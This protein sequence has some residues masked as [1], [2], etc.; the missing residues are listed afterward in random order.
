MSKNNL[1]IDELAEELEAFAPREKDRSYSKAE[2]RLVLGFEDILGFAERHERLPQDREGADI[3]ER[4]WA[5]RLEALRTNPEAVELLEPLDTAGLLD[6]D[7]SWGE[8]A[9]EDELSLDDLAE[10]LSA[11]DAGALGE[12]RH[13]RSSA[14]RASPDEVAQRTRCEDFDVFSEL[15]EQ[16]RAGLKTGV[17]ETVSVDNNKSV[18]VEDLFILNGQIAYIAQKGEEFPDGHGNTDA[19]LRVIFDNKTESNLLMRSLKRALNKDETSRRITK[20]DLGPLF[21]GEISEGDVISGTIYVL[22][23]QSKNPYI[24]EHRELIHKIGVTTGSVAKRLADAPNQATYLLAEVEV[25]AEYQL[26]GV[27]PAQF[28]KLLHR[29]LAAAQLDLT[30]KDRFGKPVH[31]REWF[32]VPL[33]VIEEI[34]ERIMD[35]TIVDH[36]YNP[37]AARLELVAL[38]E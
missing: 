4:L 37:S 12:L 20:P 6:P 2:R 25:V 26:V 14:E 31:P 11:F 34:I 17:R 27:A 10:E 16:V 5:V 8:S 3:F 19:R 15:F 7:K 22:R 32:L 18:E 9:G 30:I 36:T 38:E 35:G 28:E 21:S 29:V 1:S 13:V 33:G 24:T 23:S